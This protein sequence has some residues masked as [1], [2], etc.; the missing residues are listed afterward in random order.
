MYEGV[1]SQVSST[2]KFDEN[3]DF[4]K[5]YSGRIDMTRASKPEAEEK[6]YTQTKIY[7]RKV[8]RWHRISDTYR[9]GGMQIIYV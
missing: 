5:T 2:T 6:F 4:S 7:I 1:K 3:S 9:H 8:I